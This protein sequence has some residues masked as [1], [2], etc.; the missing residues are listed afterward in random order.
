M[1]VRS[2][3]CNIKTHPTALRFQGFIPTNLQKYVPE[4]QKA[5]WSKHEEFGTAMKTIPQG[6]ATSVYLAAHPDLEG[7]FTVFQDREFTF[8]FVV[9]AGIGGQYYEDCHLSAESKSMLAGTADHI[10][11]P[12]HAPR[13]WKITLELLKDELKAAVSAEVLAELNA[14]SPS[15]FH[16]KSTALEVIQGIDLSNKVAQTAALIVI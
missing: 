13:L 1:P 10:K 6:A 11:N 7:L 3:A 12:T 5:E 4:E 16:A 8:C 9:C 15:A 14:P 2:A